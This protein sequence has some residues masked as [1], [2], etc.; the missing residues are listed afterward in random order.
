MMTESKIILPEAKREIIPPELEEGKYPTKYDGPVHKFEFDKTQQYGQFI[1][2]VP[3]NETSI[4]GGAV[5]KLI[6]VPWD[7]R[8]VEYVVGMCKD[9]YTRY[10]PKEFHCNIKIIKRPP[11]DSNDPYSRIGTIG[12]KYTPVYHDEMSR[13]KVDRP[14][15]AQAHNF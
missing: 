4:H 11:E 9:R 5:A 15:M 10:I 14:N 2:I 3:P 13:K 8:T 7:N 12:W 1:E 6:G